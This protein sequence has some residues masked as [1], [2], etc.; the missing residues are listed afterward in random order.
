[1]SVIRDGLESQI[2]KEA[3]VLEDILYLKKGA[4]KSLLMSSV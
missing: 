1:M 3:L 4:C 2:D